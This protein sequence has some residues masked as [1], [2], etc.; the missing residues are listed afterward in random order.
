[1]NVKGCVK[2]EKSGLLYFSKKVMN[3]F[4]LMDFIAINSI[5]MTIYTKYVIGAK[6]K[7]LQLF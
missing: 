6:V 5:T 3:S 1:M 7:Y 4:Y 2:S